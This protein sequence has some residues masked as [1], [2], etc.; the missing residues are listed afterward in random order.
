MTSAINPWIDAETQ[1]IGVI[2]ALG[3]IRFT[4]ERFVRIILLTPGAQE[5]L[6][7]DPT[8][9]VPVDDSKYRSLKKTE[10]P[11]AYYIENPDKEMWVCGMFPRVAPL[12][13]NYMRRRLAPRKSTTDPLIVEMVSHPQL[14]KVSACRVI[15]TDQVFQTSFVPRMTSHESMC[16]LI[17][18]LGITDKNREKTRDNTYVHSL[19]LVTDSWGDVLKRGLIQFIERFNNPV[20]HSQTLTPEIYGDRMAEYFRS[21]FPA[22]S[23]GD[24][25]LSDPTTWSPMTTPSRL[26]LMLGTSIVDKLKDTDLETFTRLS[27]VISD[28]HITTEMFFLRILS[29]KWFS[30]LHSEPL[31]VEDDFAVVLPVRLLNIDDKDQ[32]G[33]NTNV[34]LL[35]KA[36]DVLRYAQ[37]ISDTLSKKLSFYG[38]A[39][40]SIA[41][42]LVDLDVCDRRMLSP[43]TLNADV[44]VVLE[45]QSDVR[46]WSNAF[47]MLS[48]SLMADVGASVM[49]AGGIVQV[50]RSQNVYAIKF[51]NDACIRLAKRV[52]P[53]ITQSVQARHTKRH[54]S[55]F[56]RDERHAMRMAH[57]QVIDSELARMLSQDNT[58]CFF[59]VPYLGGLPLN[60]ANS[61]LSLLKRDHFNVDHEEEHDISPRRSPSAIFVSIQ[62]RALR[63]VQGMTPFDFDTSTSAEEKDTATTLVV[64]GAERLDVR[65][66]DRMLSVLPSVNKILLAYDHTLFTPSFDTRLFAE[67]EKTSRYGRYFMHGRVVHDLLACC[68][69]PEEILPIDD[70]QVNRQIA[71]T[72]YIM[73]ETHT[74]ALCLAQTDINVI[75]TTD[76]AKLFNFALDMMTAMGTPEEQRSGELLFIHTASNTKAA[77]ANSPPIK[78]FTTHISE[79]EKTIGDE[80][81]KTSKD[82]R[83]LME[84]SC[85]WLDQF[86]RACANNTSK[87]S[88]MEIL[89]VG[90]LVR[91]HSSV[92]TRTKDS[93]A[94]ERG[95]A[96]G[97]GLYRVLTIDLCKHLAQDATSVRLDCLRSNMR[98][99]YSRKVNPST[100]IDH[101][102]TCFFVRITLAQIDGRPDYAYNLN[103]VIR[104]WN[105]NA[106]VKIPFEQGCLL[107]TNELGF[108]LGCNRIVMFYEHSSPFALYKLLYCL[109][110]AGKNFDLILHGCTYEELVRAAKNISPVVKPGVMD[111]NAPFSFA[112]RGLLSRADVAATAVTE[113]TMNNK[114]RQITNQ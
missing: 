52:V 68:V 51:V 29:E 88:T 27:H 112:A 60:F 5:L 71:L 9:G 28:Q 48:R 101:S 37:K 22:G 43:N 114:K 76:T 105:N 77:V 62:N 66:F 75:C 63:G 2:T 64:F 90:D 69:T 82:A 67:T 17:T 56:E 14:A 10:K 11:C 65:T 91:H 87:Q 39:S 100:T 45:S 26:E 50:E 72:R 46:I 15:V 103:Q 79:L 83:F 70:A 93:L 96:V 8:L 36:Y 55:Q 54:M 110:Y 106:T 25:Y 24:C 86:R 34:P 84:D 38:T 21:S 58:P 94:S 59:L 13:V 98:E 97:A 89:R 78:A 47:E 92:G 16:R 111:N 95:P 108:F 61:L 99:Q 81:R 4:G 20:G 85:P 3:P 31:S 12:F 113:M 107:S 53:L 7:N 19:R 1:L 41:E 49:F 80:Q 109:R 74:G 18:A 44:S 6:Y 33:L 40:M 57:T 32:M 73:G 30:A 35:E 23:R 104:V 102:K 42:I